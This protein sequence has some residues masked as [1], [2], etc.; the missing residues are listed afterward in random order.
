MKLNLNQMAL[1][2][3]DPE[4]WSLAK[5]QRWICEA[6]GLLSEMRPYTD[7]QTSRLRALVE[8]ELGR[9]KDLLTEIWAQSVPQR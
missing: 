1:L 4:E 5:L 6:E 3:T 7:S 8:R 9:K 2:E